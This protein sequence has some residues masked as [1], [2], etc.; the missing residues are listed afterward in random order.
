MREGSVQL[1]AVSTCAV[2][3]SAGRQCAVEGSVQLKACAGR[4][5]AGRQCVCV[6]ASDVWWGVWCLQ[7][8]PSWQASSW[9]PS[10]HA[11]LLQSSGGV[12]ARGGTLTLGISYQVGHTFG[13]LEYV[14]GRCGG[15]GRPFVAERRLGA[16]GGAPKSGIHGQSRPGTTHRCGGHVGHRPS[17][18]AALAQ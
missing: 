7:S 18:G 15:K 5:C 6:W 10:R 3:G 8:D 16:R 17:S 4:K 14:W 13:G 12:W 11:A 1:K 9:G 2:E